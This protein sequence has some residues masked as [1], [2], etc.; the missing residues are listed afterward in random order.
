MDDDDDDDDGIVSNEM[1]L[2]AKCESTVD[3][4]DGINCNVLELLLLLS[5]CTLLLFSGCSRMV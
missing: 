3:I 4:F 5:S 1:I 2:P